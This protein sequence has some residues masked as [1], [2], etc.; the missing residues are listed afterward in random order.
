M[1]V[2][3]GLV[4][5]EKC[6]TDFNRNLV[7]IKHNYSRHKLHTETHGTSGH[8]GSRSTP[9]IAQKEHIMTA[10]HRMMNDQDT[11]ITNMIDNEEDHPC[12]VE[13]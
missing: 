12:S 4:M 3:G 7:P 2:D 9:S 11:F 13:Q 8:S 10:G 5:M 6:N 1:R